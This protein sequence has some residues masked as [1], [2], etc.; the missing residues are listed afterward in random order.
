MSE[1]DLKKNE[2]WFE[3][4]LGGGLSK[5][6]EG[7]KRRAAPRVGWLAGVEATKTK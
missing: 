5:K 6:K 2:R 3:G 1:R 7:F 4:W